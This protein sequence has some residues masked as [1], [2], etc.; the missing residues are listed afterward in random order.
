MNS[1]LAPG[2]QH[3]RNLPQQEL[4]I[5]SVQ[6]DAILQG[7][8]AAE[9]TERLPGGGAQSTTGPA[10]MSLLAA[11]SAKLQGCSGHISVMVPMLVSSALTRAASPSTVLDIRWPQAH[12][13]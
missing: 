2:P 12:T 3:Y 4:R 1:E 9:V 6:K 5:M 7:A 10:H 8:P 13:L 11:K